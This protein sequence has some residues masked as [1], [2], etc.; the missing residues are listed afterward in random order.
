MDGVVLPVVRELSRL[1]EAVRTRMDADDALVS[2]LHSE[3]AA[4]RAEVAGLRM[5]VAHLRCS[6]APLPTSLRPVVARAVVAVQGSTPD[7]GHRL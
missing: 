3:L 4:L 5:A 6:A 2:D 7:P 1:E